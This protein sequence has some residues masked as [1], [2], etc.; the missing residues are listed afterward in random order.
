MFISEKPK[1]CLKEELSIL[2]D[3]PNPDWLPKCTKNGLYEPMQCEKIVSTECN[4]KSRRKRDI[5]CGK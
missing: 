2:L 3:N 5:P 1:S 4:A